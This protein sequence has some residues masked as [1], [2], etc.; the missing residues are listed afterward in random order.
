MRDSVRTVQAAFTIV[1][2]MNGVHELTFPAIER[3]AGGVLGADVERGGGVFGGGVRV[4]GEA[5]TADPGPEVAADR[6]RSLVAFELAAAP[7][8]A[9]G[10]S[11]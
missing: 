8:F 1:V 7:F 4:G 10:F 5:A 6:E 3:A 11:A 9:A 2:A